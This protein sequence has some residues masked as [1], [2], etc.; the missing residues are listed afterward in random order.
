MVSQLIRLFVRNFGVARQVARHA[1]KVAQSG[2]GQSLTEAINTGVN[3]VS[4]SKAARALSRLQIKGTLGNRY[5]DCGDGRV[6][7]NEQSGQATEG[8]DLYLSWEP[9][10]TAFVR[11]HVIVGWKA[12]PDRIIDPNDE[13]FNPDYLD[14]VWENDLNTVRRV[15]FEARGVP[16]RCV[17]FP[18]SKA[19]NTFRQL[20]LVGE[21][22][23]GGL[24][25]VKGVCLA[26]RHKR[27]REDDLPAVDAQTVPDIQV[28]GGPK[29]NA[30]EE[31]LTA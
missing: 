31:A 27:E 2:A 12:W 10:H 16:D 3:A 26:S 28:P 5:H 24:H 30:R 11:Y 29:K 17:R 15:A 7:H 22:A 4:A 13:L 9:Q 14:A 8:E 6:V 20:K 19:R 23:H 1:D 25:D 21:D 18:A